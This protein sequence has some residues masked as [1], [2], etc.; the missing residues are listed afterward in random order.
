LAA[1]AA[2]LRGVNDHRRR[3]ALLTTTIENQFA[4]VRSRID[5]LSAFASAGGTPEPARLER[6]LDTLHREQEALLDM[7][8][9][10]P[11]ETEEKFGQLR[12]RLA[13]A[14]HSTAADIAHDWATFAAAVE[15][16]LRDWD[17]YLERMQTSAASMASPRREWAEAAIADVRKRRIAID[18]RLANARGVAGDD[19]QQH[20]DRIAAARDE[21]EQKADELSANL[22]RKEQTR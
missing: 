12:T 3:L 14:E 2:S 16:E 4:E 8:A 13:V 21:L 18:D 6:H 19:W 10:P 1:A 22:K 17:S 20:R 7:S 11:A 5:R 9:D 15:G